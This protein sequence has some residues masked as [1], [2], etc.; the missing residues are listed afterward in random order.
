MAGKSNKSRNRKGS[1]SSLN[2]ALETVKGTV[3]LPKT[4]A[5][6][7]H[8]NGELGSDSK[9][10]G[11]ESSP[12][13]ETT[14]GETETAVVTENDPSKQGEDGDIHLYPVS[15]KTPSG[16]KLEL[17]LSPGD[18]VMDLRQFLLDAPETCFFTC[19][20]LI[21]QTKDGSFHH[22][23]DH[24]DISEVADITT[25]G[26]SL[27]MVDALYDDRSIRAHVQ[28]A[29]ELISLSTLHASLST[30][31]ALQQET[32][33][34]ESSDA[35]KAE[36]PELDGLGFMEDIIGSLSNL[37]SSSPEKIK[38]VQSIVFSSFNPPPSHR[39]L[40]GDLIYIDVSTMEGHSLCITGTTKM[41]YVNSSKKNILDSKPAKQP[42]L[43][44]TTLIGL[45]QKI[46][47]K[48]KKAFHEILELKAS[49]HPFENVQS[50]L[51][52]NSWLGAYPIPGN[53]INSKVIFGI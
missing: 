23:E 14:E 39:R 8:E 32:A 42:S 6:G 46:N 37:M 10:E 50:L 15:V 33:Q 29:R 2:F 45:L 13:V 40:V 31:L 27:E 30:S 35:E 3:E 22:L 16:E 25:G 12:L 11:T 43:E 51:P 44:A 49:A 17:R 7:V 38:C 34:K 20:D 18:S 52:P 53:F 36:V 28:R 24:N 5:N 9:L 4:E 41:F 47:G 19:Y 1:Q 21:L 26:C 48:F